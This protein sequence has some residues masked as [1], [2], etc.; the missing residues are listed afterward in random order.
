M[1]APK[2]KS[3]REETQAFLDELEADFPEPTP[4]AAAAGTP[5]TVTTTASTTTGLA[6]N[7][8]AGSKSGK[9][10]LTSGAASVATPTTGTTAAQKETDDASAAGVQQRAATPSLPLPAE[11]SATPRLSTDS[12]HATGTRTSMDTAGGTGDTGAAK[13][14]G[15]KGGQGDDPEADL[16]FLEAQLAAAARRP[17]SA[18]GAGLGAGA[19]GAGMGSR[20][21]TPAAGAIIGAVLQVP[22]GGRK[23]FDYQTSRSRTGTPVN[24]PTA[25][26]SA[27]AAAAAVE[28]TQPPPAAAAAGSGWGSSWWSSAST[29]LNQAKTVAIEQVAHVARQADEVQNQARDA[30]AG[31]TAGAAAS[32]PSV[33]S[34]QEFVGGTAAGA[35]AGKINLES[36]AK[37]GLGSLGQLREQLGD[38]VKGVDLERLRSELLQRGQSALSEIINTVAPPISEHEVL[39]VWFSHDMKG[40]DGVENVVYTAVESIMQQTQSTDLELFYSNPTPKQARTSTDSKT[41]AAAAADSERSINP[42]VGWDAAWEKTQEM[43]RG[44]KERT[45]TDPRKGNP[46]PELPVLTIPVYLHLQPVLVPLPFPELPTHISSSTQASPSAR[47]P[48]HLTFLVTL[49]DDVHSLQFSTVTQY[50]PRDWMDVPYDV[51]DWVEERLVDVLRNGVENIVQEYVATRMN[52]KQLPGGSSGFTSAVEEVNDEVTLEAAETEAK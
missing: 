42:V 49:R 38:R 13:G 27:A 15:G 3:K 40:Y 44:V 31:A 30:V 33:S 47:P 1:S 23:S 18:A 39:Q 19:G 6:N 17:V 2:S 48:K 46:N 4:A 37:G 50:A 26:G 36:L 51:S 11:R 14:K 12:A 8:R 9:K 45:K 41:S 10:K 20:P 29:M 24:E 7:A 32:V 5:S 28:G 52:L 34:L 22:T 35:A 16:A 43:M 25:T 21:S